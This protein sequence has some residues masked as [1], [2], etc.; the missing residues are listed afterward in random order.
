MLSKKGKSNA[1]G[2]TEG[3]EGLSGCQLNSTG[4]LSKFTKT[5]TGE[6]REERDTFQSQMF[7]FFV[8]L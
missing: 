4:K 2:D 8:C 3:V 5:E 6:T 7:L 1:E